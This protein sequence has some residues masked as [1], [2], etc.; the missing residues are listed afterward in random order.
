MLK[1]VS[2]LK[3]L[4]AKT[5][6]ALGLPFCLPLI[7]AVLKGSVSGAMIAI[8]LLCI[9][10]IPQMFMQGVLGEPSHFKVSTGSFGAFF[11]VWVSVCST[12]VIRA[13]IDVGPFVGL[14]VVCVGF[15]ISA[16][17]YVGVRKGR[18]QQDR[19]ASVPA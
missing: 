13:N 7:A 18:K 4:D 8:M 19:S 9:T 15:G 6:F 3:D 17:L 1:N 14:A 12:L 2:R 10:R 11:I 16:V 5:L